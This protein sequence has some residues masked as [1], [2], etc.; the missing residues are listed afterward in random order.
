MD[1]LEQAN[2]RLKVTLDE[3]DRERV[4][5]I[6]K[7]EEKEKQLRERLRKLDEDKHKT[8]SINGNVAASDDDV[9]EI[10]AGGKV[11]AVKR[12]T[13]TQLPG[14]RFEAMF[15]GRWEK[16][17]ALD[18]SGRL[19]LDVNS[20]CFQAIVDYMKNWPSRPM[21]NHPSRRRWTMSFSIFLSIK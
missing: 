17:L 5:Q 8:A 15:S 6:H 9:I 11:I 4:I 3:F 13:L 16:K 19:F 20:D 1:D 10:N 2:K 12:A 18:S 21:M 7:L 14:S